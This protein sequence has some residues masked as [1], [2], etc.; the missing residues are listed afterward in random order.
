MAI[1]SI[2]T[3]N[4]IDRPEAVKRLITA[5]EESAAAHGVDI[6]RLEDTPDEA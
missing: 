3:E 1:N 5:I 6:E 2:F 4:I